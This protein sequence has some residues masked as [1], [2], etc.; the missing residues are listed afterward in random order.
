MLRQKLKE[1]FAQSPLSLS[2]WR[3]SRTRFLGGVTRGAVLR[4]FGGY[5][6]FDW[7]RKLARREEKNETAYEPHCV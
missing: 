4:N 3:T 1:T 7:Q 6:S 5:F 2:V